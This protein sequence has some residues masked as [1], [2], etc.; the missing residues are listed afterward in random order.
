MSGIYIHIPFC[1]QKCN[2]C[3][4]HFSICL[5]LKNDVIKAIIKEIK[6]QKEYLKG[7]PIETIYF[8][9][10]TPSILTIKEIEDILKTIFLTFKVSSNPEITLEANP[11]DLNEEKTFGLKTIGINRLSVGVQT[12]NETFLKF[13]NRQETYGN[14]SSAI[15]NIVKCGFKNFNIDLIFGIPG[16]KKT[17]FINDLEEM[18]NIHPTH[19]SAYSL[20]VE[21]KTVLDFWIKKGIVKKIDEDIS[22]DFFL[23][24]DEYLTKEG[25]DHYEI[26]NYSLKGFKSIHN[27]NYWDDKMYLGV[28]PSAHSY[29]LTSRQYNI[30]NNLQYVK[31]INSGKIPAIIEILKEKDKINEYIFTHLRTSKGINLQVLREKYNYEIDKNIIYDLEKQNFV[32]NNGETIFLTTKGMLIADEIIKKLLY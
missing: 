28:G 29:N 5:N 21:E 12:F 4:F 25:Y 7:E 9:G 26:S 8:G 2:Y 30:E 23:I 16:Q 22:A 13:L 32:V 17:D 19:I 6:I 24:I 10:G 11:I 27:S 1:H 14:I 20:T 18:I 15:N 31:S 3:N